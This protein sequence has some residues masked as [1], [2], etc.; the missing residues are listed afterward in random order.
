MI[1]LATTISIDLLVLIISTL[2]TWRLTRRP[3]P[4][5]IEF[6]EVFSGDSFSISVTAP[7]SRTALHTLTQ[8][9]AI[10]RQDVTVITGSPA[11]DS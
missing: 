1:A 11:I 8:A 3:R 5:V 10:A 6:Q 9:R 4:V 7:T 2:V